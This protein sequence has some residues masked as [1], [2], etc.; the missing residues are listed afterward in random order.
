MLAN[1]KLAVGW[2]LLTFACRLS[3]FLVTLHCFTGRCPVLMLPG[4]QPDLPKNDSPAPGTGSFQTPCFYR[5]LES[6]A[7]LRRRCKI[8]DKQKGATTKATKSTG[9][10]RTAKWI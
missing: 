7:P 10:A 5:T 2:Q 4:F 9:V 6:P 8:R 3:A 1:G